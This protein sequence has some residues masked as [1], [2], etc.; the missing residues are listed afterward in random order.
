MKKKNN[1]DIHNNKLL[2]KLRK[3]IYIFKLH[4]KNCNFNVYVMYTDFCDTR[5]T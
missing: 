4:D 5:K 3:I 2:Y 1:P